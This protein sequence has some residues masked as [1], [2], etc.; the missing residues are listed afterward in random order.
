VS[1]RAGGI[2]GGNVDGRSSASTSR[3][4]THRHGPSSTED[5][6]YNVW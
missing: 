2:E 5:D 4:E 1:E 3:N 6:R